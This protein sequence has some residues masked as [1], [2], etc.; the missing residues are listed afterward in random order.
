MPGFS[1][2]P[3]IKILTVEYYVRS[4]RPNQWQVAKFVNGSDTPQAIYTLTNTRQGLLC[5]CSGGL[6]TRKYV[7]KHTDMVYKFYK[8]GSPTPFCLVA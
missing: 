4:L 7:C 1:K 3:Y 6:T 2:E 8:A 5:D